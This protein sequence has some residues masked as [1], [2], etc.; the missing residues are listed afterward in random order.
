MPSVEL[1]S[2][3]ERSLCTQLR[4]TP[5]TYLSV[6]ATLIAEYERLGALKLMQ[7]TACHGER[8]AGSRPAH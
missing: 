1:L 2:E 4:L 8:R 3:A 5:E 7:V 6:K